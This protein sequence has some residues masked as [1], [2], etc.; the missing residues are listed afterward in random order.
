[1]VQCNQRSMRGVKCVLK[2]LTWNKEACFLNGA[3]SAT[4]LFFLSEITIMSVAQFVSQC[5]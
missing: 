5:V 2:F 4:V 3:G 1:V